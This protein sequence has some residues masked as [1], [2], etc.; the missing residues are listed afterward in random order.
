LAVGEIFYGEG[1]LRRIAIASAWALWP[2]ILLAVPL[3]L[4]TNLITRDEKVLWDIG[5]VAM[6]ATLAWQFFQVVKTEHKF[7]TRQAVVVMALILLGMLIIWVL[8]G[9]VYALTGEIVQFV[10]QIALELYVRQY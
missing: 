8:L 9:L 10:R 3:N 4:A 7:E 1:S 5:Q 6:W 2:L